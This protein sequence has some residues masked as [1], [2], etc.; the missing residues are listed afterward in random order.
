MEVCVTCRNGIIVY[1]VLKH[2][3]TCFSNILILVLRLV[4]K[5]ADWC[6]T[7]LFVSLS[8][9]CIL[10]INSEKFVLLDSKTKTTLRTCPILDLQQWSTGN[11]KGHSGLVLEFRGSKPWNLVAPSVDDLKSVTSTLWDV[12]DI[13][14]RFLERT[15]L[16]R[17]V[18]NFGERT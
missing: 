8:Q 16:H 10:G 4:F 9:A 14:G 5:V 3:N 15:P 7:F 13:S 6:Y 2:I 11:G 18:L 17:D 12:M 1:S